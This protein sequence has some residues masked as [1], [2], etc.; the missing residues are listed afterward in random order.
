[1]KC[2]VATR[3]GRWNT[4]EVVFVSR[5]GCHF[6]RVTGN[7]GRFL[8]VMRTVSVLGHVYCVLKLETNSWW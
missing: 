1:M 7:V 6:G 8:V 4:C 5:I 3:L 2:T